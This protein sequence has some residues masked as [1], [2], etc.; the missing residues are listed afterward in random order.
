[1]L[2]E[3]VRVIHTKGPGDSILLVLLGNSQMWNRAHVYFRAYCDFLCIKL[4]NG[5]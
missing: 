1:M 2:K 4:M 5:V 3:T